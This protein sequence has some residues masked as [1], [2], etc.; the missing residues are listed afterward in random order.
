MKLT[1]QK[2]AIESATN[3][4]SKVINAK[5]A[6]PIL[7][8][9]LCE[10]KD[11]Q[12][13][14]TAS[15]TE[16]TMQRTIELESHEGEGTF[17]V[18]A[19]WLKSALSQLPEQPLTVEADEN[20]LRFTITHDS[21]E[22]F[23]PMELAED[24]PLPKAEDY[25]ADMEMVPETVQ[26]ALK[27]SMWATANDELRP[28]MNGVCFNIT[29]EYVDIVATDAHVLVRTRLFDTKGTGT[30]Q[31]ILPNKAAN[32]L[33]GLLDI[34]GEGLH[35]RVNERM[36]EIKRAPFTM[37]CRLVEGKFPNYESI[38]PEDSKI[39]ANVSR[40]GII[41]SIRKVIPFTQDSQ[42]SKRISMTFETDMVTLYGDDFAYGFG[43][44]DSLGIDYSNETF[45]IAVGGSLL[46]GMF[47]RLEDSECTMMMTDEKHVIVIEPFEQ[48]EDY[49]VLMLATP[50]ILDND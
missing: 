44:K 43:A 23:F 34:G 11:N 47:T 38:I 20:T 18:N 1:V 30:L 41:N 14:M 16:I 15:D 24:Y 25:T 42:G 12:L 19:G 17:C 5:S 7:S 4:L 45:R 32:V 39:F 29:D 26:S 3:M 31:F 37:T 22:T 48:K 2:S 27:R 36:C 13:A 50:M 6:L 33:A 9:I 10:V 28:T 21:G 40:P 8:D 35:V 49:N 46:L